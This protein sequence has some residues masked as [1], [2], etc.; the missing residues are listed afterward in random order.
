MVD[1]TRTCIYGS[2]ITNLQVYCSDDLFAQKWG[3]PRATDWLSEVDLI[4]RWM[5]IFGI[6]GELLFGVRLLSIFCYSNPRSYLM[7][8]VL[9]EWATSLN[10]ASWS[11]IDL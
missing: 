3:I 8:T 1:G 10:R 9:K 6:E 5:P 4:E 11:I 7:S 2:F